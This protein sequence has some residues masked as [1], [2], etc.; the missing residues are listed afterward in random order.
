MTRRVNIPTEVA[1]DWIYWLT[2]WIS[3]NLMPGLGRPGKAE[4]P[5]EYRNIFQ[6]RITEDGFCPDCRS[7]LVFKALLPSLGRCAKC[8]REYSEANLSGGFCSDCG[9][10]V[11]IDHGV[12]SDLAKQRKLAALFEQ[13]PA[14]KKHGFLPTKMG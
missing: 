2:G 13:L 5:P 6:P 8:S 3:T 7:P 4:L 11:D 12:K 1:T 10:P 9:H 14:L